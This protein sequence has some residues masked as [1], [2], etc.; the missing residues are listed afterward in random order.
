MKKVETTLKDAYLIKLE[1]YEDER[2]FFIKSFN[3]KEHHYE[4]NEAILQLPVLLQD[5]H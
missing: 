4:A 5:N 1:K 3:I 2:G